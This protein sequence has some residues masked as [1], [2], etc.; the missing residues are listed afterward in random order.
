MSSVSFPNNVFISFIP[1]GSKAHGR[2]VM[3]WKLCIHRQ[4]LLNIELEY[5]VMLYN[6][7][8]RVICIKALW[9]ILQFSSIGSTCAS[10][11]SNLILCNLIW[12][13]TYSVAWFI[14]ALEFYFGQIIIF[15]TFLTLDTQSCILRLL[16]RL[17]CTS[18]QS[19]LDL[20]CWQT[21]CNTTILILVSCEI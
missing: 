18:V 19:D 1:Q 13:Q 6:N 15:D 9:M 4:D 21:V 10:L 16:P 8:Y 7:K 3:G 20:H 14:L 11:A 17:D 12:A 5:Y 2:V